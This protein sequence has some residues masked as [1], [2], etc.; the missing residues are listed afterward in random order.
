MWKLDHKESWVLKNGCFWT[1][2]LE[3]TL[4]SPLD[5]NEIKPVNPKGNQ[6]WILIGRSGVGD[7]PIIWSPD[8]KSWLIG[9]D[10]D[11]GKDWGQE[12]KGVT[13]DERLDGITDSMDVSLSK[14][15][16]IVKD[17]MHEL[18]AGVHGVTKS[19]TRLSDWT[20]TTL[21]LRKIVSVIQE[22]EIFF[23]LCHTNTNITLTYHAYNIYI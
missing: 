9:K 13:E 17:S 15:K 21:C 7:A 22:Y 23:C 4:E 5:N 2:M 19:W 14:L 16:E 11:L 1:V 6:P 3:K 8:A 10:P 18:H 20:T 12:E